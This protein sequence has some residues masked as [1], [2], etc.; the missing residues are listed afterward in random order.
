[1]HTCYL[2][3]LTSFLDYLEPKEEDSSSHINFLIWTILSVSNR[4]NYYLGT[5]SD[6]ELPE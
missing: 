6:T 3:V 5:L 1:M 4:G 2:I